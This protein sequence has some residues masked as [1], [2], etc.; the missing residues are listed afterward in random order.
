M[1]P[2]ADVPTRCLTGCTA[3][4]GG[5]RSRVSKHLEGIGRRVRKSAFERNLPRKELAAARANVNDGLDPAEDRCHFYPL[6]A[7]CCQARRVMGEERNRTG[8]TRW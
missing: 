7:A 1:R 2:L 5:R 3:V 6:R 4:D 8:R